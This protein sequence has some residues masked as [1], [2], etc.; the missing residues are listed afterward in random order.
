[1]SLVFHG[2]PIFSNGFPR[3]LLMFRW[4]SLIFP[5]SSIVARCF[6]PFPLFFFPLVLHWFSF[7]CQLCSYGVVSSNLPHQKRC[8]QRLRKYASSVQDAH[9]KA[10]LSTGHHAA[11][12]GASKSSDGFPF[13]TGEL[14]RGEGSKTC[15]NASNKYKAVQASK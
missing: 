14:F 15:T 7:A 12:P 9:A 2:F 13:P 5:S 6:L 1:M 10:H 4:F 11:M 8:P 3:T